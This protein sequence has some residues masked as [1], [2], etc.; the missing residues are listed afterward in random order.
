MRQLRFTAKVTP[1]AGTVA[2]APPTLNT[3]LGAWMASI[4]AIKSPKGVALPQCETVRSNVASVA[5]R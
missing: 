3:R 1:N 5:E 2:V 4:T